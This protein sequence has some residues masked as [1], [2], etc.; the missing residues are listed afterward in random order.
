M[1][2]RSDIIQTLID[3]YGLKSYLEIGVAKLNT[4][5]KIRC[6]AK[7]GIDPILPRDQIESFGG[8]L[9]NVTSDKFFEE[10][11]MKFDIIFIDGLH[12]YEQ[13]VKDM[14]NSYNSLNYGGFIILH[15]CKPESVSTSLKEPE[16]PLS[17]WNGDV[18]KAIIWFRTEYPHVKCF[19]LYTDWGCGVIHKKED[20]TILNPSNERLEEF[21]KLDY[22]WLVNN[23]DRLGLVEPSYLY[24]YIS[25]EWTS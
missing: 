8:I 7:T 6:T 22:N 10:N 3:R 2:E 18:Y 13:T 1:M 23:I 24:K 16:S 4:F 20:I 14:V 25:N 12:V 21:N 9:G 19:V 17:S 5:S 15:D 11:H